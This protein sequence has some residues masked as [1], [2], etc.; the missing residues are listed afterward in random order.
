MREITIGFDTSNYTTSCALFDGAEGENSGRLLD[1]AQGQL[2][3]RQSDALFSHVKRL[4]EIVERLD[5]CGD[6]IAVGASEKPRETENSYMP[7]FLAGVAQGRVLAN[8]L[9][10][11]YFGFSHQQGHIAAAAWS[12]GR[13]D[14]LEKEHLAWHLSGGTTE[15]LYVRPFGVAVKC[16]IIGGTDDLAVGQLI[17]RAGQ[18]LGL[19]FPS[20][21]ELD[22]LAANADKLDKYTPKISGMSFSVSGI[23]HKMKG[24]FENG[25]KAEN[26]AYFTLASVVSAV[27]AA[28]ENAIAKYGDMPVLYSGG[29][30]S[31]S[32]LRR[33]TPDG[34]F[35]EPRYSTDNAMGCAILTYRA[36]KDGK[37]DIQR[38]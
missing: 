11:P 3:L 15:L 21:K 33:L 34:I 13:I 24:I 37:T 19:S 23:E 29:V 35:A 7:C 18:L 38:I 8:M 9:G 16:E 28:T 10:V 6:I 5:V 32:L 2:G 31:N 17:D 4:P 30:A 12:A 20:G 14:L 22:A 36:V 27:H 26:I 25:E 1:V